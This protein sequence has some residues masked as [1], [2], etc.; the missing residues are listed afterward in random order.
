MQELAQASHSYE[1]FPLLMGTLWERMT[2]TDGKNWRWIYKSLVVL[3]YMIR[4][5]S[6]NVVMEAR[7]KGLLVDLHDFQRVEEEKDVGVNVRQKS[8]N[9]VDLLRDGERL[10]GEREKVCFLF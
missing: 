5:G 6:M 2:P 10:E 9:I 4:C 7:V 8:K 3:E 1:Q